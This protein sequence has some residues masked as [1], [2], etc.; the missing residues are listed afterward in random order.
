MGNNSYRRW[1][2]KS[3]VGGFSFLPVRC[4]LLLCAMLA[5]PLSADVTVTAQTTECN[6][7][8]GFASFSIGRLYKIQEGPCPDP[9]DPSKNLKQVLLKDPTYQFQVLWVTAE[10]SKV[11]L[12]QI[13]EI[14]SA[15]L[16]NLNK[17]DVVVERTIIERT[18]VV[19]EPPAKTAAADPAGGSSDD[20]SSVEQP[21]DDPPRIELIDPPLGNTRSV[22]QVVT[23]S[24]TEVR[25]LVGKARA[26]SGI[27]SVTI[28]GER[29]TVDEQGIFTAEIPVKSGRT[30]ISIVAVDKSGRNSTVDLAFIREL[31]ERSASGSDSGDSGD[32]GGP[33]KG[34]E[35]FGSYHALIIANNNYDS[36][37]DLSTPAN[38][39]NAVAEALRDR[40]GFE[41][42]TLF[43][44][45]RYD[46][47]T[48][49][50][51]MRRDL[52]DKDNLLIY[53]AG[54]GAYDKVNNRGHWLPVDAESDSTANWISTIEITDI[55]NAMSATHVLVVADSCYS[56][57]LSRSENTDL[58]PG[59]SPELRSQWLRA[60]AEAKSRHVLT[61]G[62][63]KPVVD[64]AGN[65]HSVFANAFITALQE[66]DGALES[67]ELYRNVE[68]RVSDRAR[69]LA[70]DQT[71]QYAQLKNTGHEFGEFILVTRQFKMSDQSQ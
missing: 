50:N 64:D 26:D 69:E 45:T 12:D 1:N 41:V 63:V 7:D 65:G 53:F 42:E 36:L 68:K 23:A 43:D 46:I 51:N 61:S 39:A 59:M 19:Q 29:Q 15:R 5:A 38:D 8:T 71:P 27:L 37:T 22:N 33:G 6:G 14:K 18:E 34:N 67:S 57:A 35:V 31:P 48:A 17:P 21:N 9:A 55:V 2:D 25:T 62:G 32:S 20:S 49:L 60:M 10:E 54:H 24:D 30:P 11:I 47:L 4:A 66:G 52:T 3:A 16:Q 44:A 58:D 13:N 40:Y 56:G 28:N 70:L